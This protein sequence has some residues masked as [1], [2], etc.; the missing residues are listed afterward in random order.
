MGCSRTTEL[1]HQRGFFGFGVFF[2]AG[3]LCVILTVLEL[4]AKRFVLLV[5]MSVYVYMWCIGE[6]VGSPGA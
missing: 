2:G 6:G 3:F 5:I 1:N 4:M